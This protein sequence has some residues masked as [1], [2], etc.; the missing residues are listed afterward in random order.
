MF[1]HRNHTTCIDA[2]FSHIDNKERD[3]TTSEKISLGV[4]LLLEYQRCITS[5]FIC[6]ANIM[7]VCRII[8]TRSTT[9]VRGSEIATVIAYVVSTYT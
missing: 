7:G 5:I 6:M 2:F 8:S 1:L 4:M 3:N 9:Y